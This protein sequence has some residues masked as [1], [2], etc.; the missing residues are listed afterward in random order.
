M[1]SLIAALVLMANLGLGATPAATLSKD[2]PND[3]DISYWVRYAISH[4]ARTRGVVVQIETTDG[5]VKL[6][7]IV[8]NLAAKNYAA[9]EAE[10]ISGV[11][12]VI[13]EIDVV[14]PARSDE[15]ISHDI[16]RR[17]E[18]SPS[19]DARDIFTSVSNGAVTLTG[20]ARDWKL[21]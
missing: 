18:S 6:T 1:T 19:V 13:N 10:K 12:G 11:L 15:D 14:P 3:S 16:R 17:L 7:G 9:A 4:D 2:R 20:T 21:G 5:I 8:D